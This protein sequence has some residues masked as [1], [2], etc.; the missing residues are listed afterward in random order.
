MLRLPRFLILEVQNVSLIVVGARTAI[1]SGIALSVLVLIILLRS[2]VRTES[3]ICL[4]KLRSDWRARR[5]RLSET[6][7]WCPRP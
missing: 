5:T 3:I 6:L 7:L 4:S 1:G 2:V